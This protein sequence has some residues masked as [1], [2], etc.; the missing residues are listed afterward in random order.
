MDIVIKSVQMGTV[1]TGVVVAGDQHLVPVWKVADPL[2]KIKR[3][4]LG[5]RHREITAVHEDVRLREVP[6]AA[7][8]TVGVGQMQD[9][10]FHGVKLINSRD[11]DEYLRKCHQRTRLVSR[12]KGN[13][14]HCHGTL[15]VRFRKADY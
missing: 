7:V 13:S 11:P 6:Q 2:Q 12:D 1:K 14:F 9:F 3:L 5:S 4:C 8:D 15:P 10:Q